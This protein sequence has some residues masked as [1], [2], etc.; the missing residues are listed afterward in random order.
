MI[1]R[2]DRSDLDIQAVLRAEIRELKFRHEVEIALLH[3]AYAMAINGPKDAMPTMPEQIAL[4]QTCPLFDE[5]WYYRAYP[6]VAASAMNAAE[7]YAHAGAF[8]GRNPG[9]HFDTMAYFLAN[10]DVAREG[11]AALVHYAYCGKAEGRS[12]S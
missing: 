12:L 1:T 7:H 11:W 4:L 2:A 10:P 3:A 6:D 8:E 5:A 9:P